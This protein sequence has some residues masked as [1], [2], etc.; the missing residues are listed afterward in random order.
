V[1]AEEDEGDN[2]SFYDSD[3]QS[4]SQKGSGSTSCSSSASEGEEAGGSGHERQQRANADANAAAAADERDAGDGTLL[5]PGL[6]RRQRHRDQRRPGRRRGSSDGASLTAEIPAGPVP[7]RQRRR[8]EVGSV[9][10]PEPHS[11]TEDAEV[12]LVAMLVQA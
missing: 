2:R 4:S 7:Q 10:E 12:A 8:S 3:S 11:D 5:A 6:A 1:A 9:L